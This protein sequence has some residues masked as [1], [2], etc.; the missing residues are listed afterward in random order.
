MKRYTYKLR[1]HPRWMRVL[2]SCLLMAGLSTSAWAESLSGQ[3]YKGY[4]GDKPVTLY[5]KTED[6]CGLGPASSGMYRYD[7]KSEWLELEITRSDSQF[8]MVEDGFTGLLMVTRDGK[9]LNGMWISPDRKRQWPVRLLEAPLSKEDVD[10][11]GNRLE[12]L[13]YGNHDC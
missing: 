1:N 12:K 10:T 2:L 6:A 5:L 13:N 11:Y 8:A 4:V 7:G 3:L 9:Q